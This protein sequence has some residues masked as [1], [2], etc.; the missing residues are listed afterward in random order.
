M[1]ILMISLAA[2]GQ[3]LVPPQINT[4]L[5]QPTIDST[6]MLW[7]DDTAH[8]TSGQWS[9]R[10]QFGY[11]DDLLVYTAKDGESMAVVSEL[12]QSDVLVGY[13][14]GRFRMGLDVPVYL[15]ALSAV[16][17]PQSGLGDIATDAKLVVLSR[18]QR[19]IGFAL[20]V[21]GF[22]P[23][24]TIQEALSTT[25]LGW[26][27]SAIVDVAVSP[28]ILLAA[29]VGRRSRPDAAFNNVTW[30]DQIVARVGAGYSAADVVGI[31]L[32][33]AGSVLQDDR[34]NAAGLPVEMTAGAWVRST[35]SDLILRGGLGTGLTDAI[36]SPKVRTMISLG[37]EPPKGPDPDND[38]VVDAFDECPSEP[39]DID[40]Y[41]DRDGCPEPTLVLLTFN[42]VGGG[43]LHDVVAIVSGEVL[44]SGQR[45][46]YLAT[47]T[48]AVSVDRVGFQGKVTEINVLGGQKQEVS[49]SLDRIVPGVVSVS[50]TDMAGVRIDGVTWVLDGE[51]IRLPEDGL[52]SLLPGV[53]RLSATAEG[54]LKHTVD[55]DVYSAQESDLAMV[56][57]KTSTSVSRTEIGLGTSQFAFERRRS[58]LIDTGEQGESNDRLLAHL[59]A[60]LKEYPQI[61]RVRVESYTT[62][63]GSEHSNQILSQSRADKIVELLTASGV[64]VSRL[65][66]K[67]MVESQRIEHTGP[68][69]SVDSDERMLFIVEEWTD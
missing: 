47:G 30:G 18:H 52:L 31:S 55:I 36:G 19:R 63:V 53:H 25:E 26:E 32:E 20:G 68:Q 58:V 16:R 59:T 4:Q 40:G 29:N 62:R 41:V 44:S 45:T 61:R 9:G 38:G 21:R 50:A 5:Y 17:G 43:E 54:H 57:E 65:V 7:T 28:N 34:N 48:H 14:F 23:T 60:I 49:V 46:V 33:M 69:A 66:A 39:E 56:L 13:S 35:S 8:S 67:G 2:L 3:N 10:I 11:A 6:Q 15:A 42:E 64:E 24:S 51:E 27:T 1:W 22:F 37:Y 12:Y